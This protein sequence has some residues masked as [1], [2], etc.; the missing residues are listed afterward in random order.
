MPHPDAVGGGVISILHL[1]EL[2]HTEVQ[3]ACFG[4]Q[5]EVLS[6]GSGLEHLALESIF[7]TTRLRCVALSLFCFCL[8]KPLLTVVF[9]A[10]PCISLTPTGCT[11]SWCTQTFV[12]TMTSGRL[13]FP[14]LPARTLCT[15][16]LTLTVPGAAGLLFWLT[17]LQVRSFSSGVPGHSAMLG[18]G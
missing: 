18:D 1:K 4:A 16:S 13:L 2:R 9:K 3:A 15:P 10:C 12:C 5:V 17:P 14:N 11:W 6:Q 8:F 7:L